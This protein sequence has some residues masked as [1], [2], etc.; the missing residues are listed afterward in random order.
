MNVV[1]AVLSSGSIGNSYVFTDGR[2]TVMVDAG[3]TMRQT[4]L[5]LQNINLTP[6]NIDAIFITHLHPDHVK[7]ARK[8]ALEYNIPVYINEYSL[9]NDHKAVEKY[10]LDEYWVHPIKSGVTLLL[11]DSFLITPFDLY[12]DAPGTVG[13]TL[14]HRYSGKVFCIITDTGMVDETGI[15]AVDSADVLFLEANYDDDMLDS[16]PYPKFLKDR[17]RSNYGHLSNNDATDILNASIDNPRRKVYFIHV[18]ENN[19]CAD[20][21]EYALE[22]ISN[23]KYSSAYILKRGEFFADWI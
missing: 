6:D 7:T 5:R 9:N 21:I 23:M 2:A 15:D 17:I 10:G 16:G 13:Y 4:L 14:K 3:I 19:N 20:A 1:Y 8:L 22:E 18:S 11:G 12:H